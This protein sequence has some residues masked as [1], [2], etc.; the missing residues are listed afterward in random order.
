MKWL[1]AFSITL[2]LL[3]ACYVVSALVCFDSPGSDRAT[4]LWAGFDSKQI[5]LHRTR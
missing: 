5:G 1:I 2:G 4:S 3:A